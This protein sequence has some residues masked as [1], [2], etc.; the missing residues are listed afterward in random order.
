MV[1]AQQ[2]EVGG[3]QRGDAVGKMRKTLDFEPYYKIASEGRF[4]TSEKLAGYAKIARERLSAD[5]FEERSARS[6]WGRS[7][8]RPTRGSAATA[9]MEAIRLKV[10]NLF[11]EH[12][13]DEFTGKFHG[14]VQAVGR[15]HRSFGQQVGS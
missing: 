10:A 15:R 11:P 4:R 2:P 7:R 14:L 6:T 8:R 3:V 9:A 5:K 13:V 12:E 1:R